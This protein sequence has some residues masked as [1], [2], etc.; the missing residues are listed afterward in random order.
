MSI[1]TGP[2]PS[3]GSKPRWWML[4][5]VTYWEP[6]VFVRDCFITRAKAEEMGVGA[7]EVREI[8]LSPFVDCSSIGTAYLV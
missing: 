5:A 6:S 1:Q 2:F 4:V 8:A 7:Y 3:H